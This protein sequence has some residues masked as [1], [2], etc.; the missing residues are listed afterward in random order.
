MKTQDDARTCETIANISSSIFKCLRYTWDTP[1]RNTSGM[2]SVLDVQIWLGLEQPTAQIH[3]QIA[4]KNCPQKQRSETPSRVILFRFYKKPMASRQNNR[5][6]AGIPDGSKI[7]TAT[8]EVIRRY[9]NT[10]RDLPEN[11]IEEVLLDYFQELRECVYP[12][13]IR[14]EVL[15]SAS[16]GFQRIWSLECE[17][18]GH[19]N[20][21][22][23]ATKTQRRADKLSP[24]N[25]FRKT[26]KEDAKE[27]PK[28]RRKP[29][30]P[31]AE[32]ETIMFCPYTPGSVLKKQLTNME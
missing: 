9:K 30:N 24:H 4:A 21:P 6:S 17:G 20:R 25:W 31:E 16:K 23:S 29:K 18:K 27:N 5:Y 2:M 15:T 3:P 11:H 7:A 12:Q 26:R 22:G 32:I 19:V 28:S 8:Q 10:S 13:S 1:S 14:E